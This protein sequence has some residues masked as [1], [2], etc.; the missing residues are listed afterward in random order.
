MDGVTGRIVA[1]PIEAIGI[2]LAAFSVSILFHGFSGLVFWRTGERIAISIALTSGS[3]NLVLMLV[4]IGDAMTP[5][6]GLY[7]AIAQVPIYL[8]PAIIQTIWRTRTGG[9]GPPA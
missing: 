3:R 8:M 2:L 9:P 4:I 1:E 7:V 5:A 6:F